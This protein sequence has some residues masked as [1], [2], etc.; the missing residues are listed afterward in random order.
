HLD[1]AVANGDDGTIG[2]YLGNGDGTLRPPSLVTLPAGS[3]PQAIALA[4]FNGDGKLDL[5]EADY[6]T[7]GLA[8]GGAVRVMFGNGDGTFQPPVSYVAGTHLTAV[9]IGDFDGDGKPDVAAVDN[10]SGSVS[11]LLNDGTGQLK[12]PVSYFTGV[13]SYD[14]SA[15]DLAKIGK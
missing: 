14:L 12:V 11:V 15:V 3:F 1:V 9:V 7:S 4:D 13:G 8:S 10:A 2:I 6:N 5:V